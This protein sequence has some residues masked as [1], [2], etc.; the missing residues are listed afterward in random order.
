MYLRWVTGVLLKLQPYVQ[1]SL[2]PRAGEVAYKLALP[3]SITVHPVFHVSQLK[4]AVGDHLPSS[5]ELPE[6]LEKWQVPEKI[7]QR[8]MVTRGSSSI[9]QVLV[10]SCVGCRMGLV[11]KSVRVQILCDPS[12]RYEGTNK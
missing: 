1:S 6:E 10:Q 12:V 11:K 2:Q 5:S 3:S 8:R 7:L 9:A 4:P